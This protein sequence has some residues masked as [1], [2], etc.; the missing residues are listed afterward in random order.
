MGDAGQELVWVNS[1][2]SP[3][4]LASG[5]G[6]QLHLH[7]QPSGGLFSWVRMGWRGGQAGEKLS[8]EKAKLPV[9]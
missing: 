5:A 6:L 4:I 3:G 1:A 9:H 8:M 2:R 7:W